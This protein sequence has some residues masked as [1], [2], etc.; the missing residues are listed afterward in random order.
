MGGVVRRV[1][2]PVG[3]TAADDEAPITSR[4]DDMY[5]R[6][7]ADSEGGWYPVGSNSFWHGGVHLREEP[8]AQVFACADGDVVAARLAPPDLAEGYIGSRNFILLEHRREPSKSGAAAKPTAPPIPPGVAGLPGI[9]VKPAPAT[10]AAPPS[11]EPQVFFSVLVHLGPLEDAAAAREAFP[12]FDALSDQDRD[13]LAAGEVVTPRISV[14]CGAPLWVVGPMGAKKSAATGVHW[15]VFS[16]DNLFAGDPA[17][18]TVED[19]DSDCFMEVGELSELFG[20]AAHDGKIDREELLAFYDDPASETSVTKLRSYACRFRSEWSFRWLEPGMTEGLKQNGFR[21]SPK[22]LE[23]RFGPYMWWDEVAASGL[24]PA[25]T[26]ADR[27]VWHYNPIRLLEALEAEFVAL[28]SAPFGARASAAELKAGDTLTLSLEGL[29]QVRGQTLTIELHEPSADADAQLVA[30]L[31]AEVDPG[32]GAVCAWRRG[33]YPAAAADDE[34]L[35]EPT[36]DGVKLAGAEGRDPGAASTAASKALL[37]RAFLKLAV[38]GREEP[39]PVAVRTGFRQDMRYALEL[40]VVDAEGTA[41]LEEPLAVEL[42]AANVGF[43][44]LVLAVA[45]KGH[46]GTDGRKQD[47]DPSYGLHCDACFPG[48]PCATCF[49]DPA[50]CADCDKAP[51]ACAAAGAECKCKENALCRRERRRKA[52]GACRNDSGC[53]CESSATC[54]ATRGNA[55]GACREDTTCKCDEAKPCKQ[56][57]CGN[58]VPEDVVYGKLA[59][60]TDH[61]AYCSGFTFWVWFT[62]LKQLDLL[63]T[64]EPDALTRAQK[65]WYG[66]VSG[67]DRTQQIAAALPAIQLGRPLRGHLATPGANETAFPPDDPTIEQPVAGDF[68]QL[69]RRSGSG[70]SVV[71]LDWAREGDAVVGVKYLSTQKATKGEGIHTEYFSKGVRK[72]ALFFARFTGPQR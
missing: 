1:V 51:K 14:P 13:R 42:D 3:A 52:A 21:V 44:E 56:K 48:G 40:T 22:K 67:P 57:P 70:H 34:E 7:E 30:R 16:R 28:K 59:L 66:N 17:W 26:D 11:A 71:F 2:F 24:L 18:P 46:L 50:A 45:H 4:R 36:V 20:A 35:A 68:L 39:L 12:W 10:P 49:D 58:G 25:E 19:A 15:E 62:C 8:G 5:R 23:R 43:N 41:L 31:I 9:T 72:N 33:D 69:W 38:Q 47:Y 37:A 54:K 65:Q 32:G 64:L 6:T 29:Y 53:K 63:P 61:Y 55:A 60:E 27:L